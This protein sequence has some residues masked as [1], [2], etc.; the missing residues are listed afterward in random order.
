MPF[1]WYEG[2]GEKV[3]S[4]NLDLSG[5]GHEITVILT[6]EAAE[7]WNIIDTQDQPS[8]AHVV[9]AVGVGSSPETELLVYGPGT[10]E[11][12]L[13]LILGLLE[14]SRLLK[15]HPV[16]FSGQFVQGIFLLI[17][18]LS[19]IHVHF[20]QNGIFPLLTVARFNE[21]GFLIFIDFVL[22]LSFLLLLEFVLMKE[23]VEDHEIVILGD[24]GRK[25]IVFLEEADQFL[26]GTVVGQLLWGFGFSLDKLLENFLSKLFAT[27]PIPVRWHV[28]CT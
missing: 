19:W 21:S 3:A 25:R 26:W 2:R 11:T 24:E 23:A 5:R 8:T 14:G 6:V 17:L 12:G 15:G 1:F 22:L 13:T 7:W 20:F 4:W 16:H 9:V 10:T 18:E 28:S 27:L